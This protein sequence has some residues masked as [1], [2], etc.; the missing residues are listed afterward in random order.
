[1]KEDHS[2][3]ESQKKMYIRDTK[4][5]G[6]NIYMCSCGAVLEKKFKEVELEHD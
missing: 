1:M 3:C 4:W 5:V 6:T 2:K